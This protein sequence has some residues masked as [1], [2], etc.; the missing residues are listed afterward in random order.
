MLVKTR[1]SGILSS[2][3]EAALMVFFFVGK[4][5]TQK[6]LHLSIICNCS[7]GELWGSPLSFSGPKSPLAEMAPF[8]CAAAEKAVTEQ[9]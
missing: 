5:A 4:K 2:F 7:D 9:G 6:M 8:L 1:V 3:G